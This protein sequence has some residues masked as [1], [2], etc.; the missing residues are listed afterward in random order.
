MLHITVI[1]AGRLKERFWTDACDE[2]L[3]RLKPYADVRMMEVPDLDPAKC[4]GE[5]KAVQQESESILAAIPK[6]THVILCDIDGKAISSEDIAESLEKLPLEG[7]ND[8][9]F[10]IGGSCGV[11]EA[12]RQ[13]ADRRWSFGRIT[14]PHNLA[15]VVLLEQIY[16]ACKIIR[17]E[18]YHK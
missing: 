16:R 8:V 11:S 18:P 5:A 14:L 7:V 2:Y 15:R 4:G 1:A 12:V 3:K 17:H 13:R 10:V 6:S 9:A